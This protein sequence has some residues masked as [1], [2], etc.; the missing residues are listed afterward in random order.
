MDRLGVVKD[1]GLHTDNHLPK[2]ARLAESHDR[3]MIHTAQ[4]KGGAPQMNRL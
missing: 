2:G 4:S 3:I 1:M